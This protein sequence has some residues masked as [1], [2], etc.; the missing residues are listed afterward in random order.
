MI[1]REDVA[2]MFE[3]ADFERLKK[4]WHKCLLSLR[5]R[6]KW[7]KSELNVQLGTIVL[8][9]EDNLSV[10]FGRL[11]RSFALYSKNY[12][13]GATNMENPAGVFQ[14]PFRPTRSSIQ[15]VLELPSN[16]REYVR[17]RRVQ[18]N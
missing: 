12:V 8:L 5:S 11:C 14:R 1:K 18:Y 17:A 2:A 9:M 15:Q 13:I 16:R 6:A 3:I 10:Q 7:M 4:C